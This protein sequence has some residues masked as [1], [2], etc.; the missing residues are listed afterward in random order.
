MSTTEQGR[1]AEM[2]VARHVERMGHTV[3][4]QNW[5]TR[6][7]E[8]DIITQKQ[9]TV[10]IIEVKYRAHV[11]WGDGIEAI[12]DKKLA[13]MQYAATVWV[14]HSGWNGDVALMVA[15]VSGTPPKLDEL[16]E[17]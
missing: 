2:L 4:A 6:S 11:T 16:F 3:L 15:S 17:V 9:H 10:F 13:Q 12:T 14:A 1:A 5:R 7:C 8:I